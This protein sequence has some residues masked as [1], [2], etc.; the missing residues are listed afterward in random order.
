VLIASQIVT[1][2]C[3]IAK[4][5]GYI[6]Q[7]GQY[8]NLV[9]N[10]LVLHR[11]LKLNRVTESITV[12]SG[13]TGPFNLSADYL[14]TY[15]M[16]YPINGMPFFL[17][18]VSTEQYDVEFQSPSVANYPYEFQT[19][20]SPQATTPD[21]GIA[22]LYIYPQT[23][24]ALTLT[25]RYMIRRPDITTPQSSASVPWFPDQDYLIHATAARLMK[26]TDDARL[27]QFVQE[28]EDMLRT[29]II[30]D[31]DEQ[32]VVKEVRLDPRRFRIHNRLRPTKVTG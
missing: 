7:G 9:L 6:S 25:H 1:Q 23:N 32:K 3:Q 12:T 31:G 16:F 18:P 22:L 28:G 14:R 30:M 20:L 21:T 15:D 29:H 5:P 10:D 27:A 24:A 17:R 13:S 2:A 26:I 19:D 4:C 8:L 11:D